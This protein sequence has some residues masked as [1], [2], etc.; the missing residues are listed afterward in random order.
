[1]KYA[2]RTLRRAPGFTAAAV[3]TLAL[4]I[5]ANTTMFGIIN[6][7]LLQRLPFPEPE[8]LVMLWQASIQDRS[9][10]NIVSMPN[11]QD[12]LERSRS[13]ASI[14]LQDSAGRGYSVTGQGEGERVPGLRVTASFFEVLG[15]PPMLG[16]TFLKEEELAGR[17]R[18]VVLSHG[19]WTRRYAADAAIVGKTILVDGKSFLVIG[20]MPPSFV[21]E[22]GGRRELWVPVGWTEGDRDRTSNSF[23]ALARLKPGVSLE[24]AR[25]EMDTIGRALSAEY[26]IQNPKQTVSVDAMSDYGQTRKRSQLAPMLAVV[27]FVLLIACANVANLMLARAASRSR[28]LAVRAALGAGRGRIVRQLLTESV[29]LACAGGVGGLMLAYWGA[30]AIL[31]VLP[32]S[33]S[34]S[35][36]RPVD[37]VAIDCAGPGLYVGRR[38]R[39]RHPVRPGPGVGRVPEQPGQSTAPEHARL[40]RRRQEPA[41]LRVGRPRSGADADRAR[42][43]WGHAGERPRGCSASMPGSIRGTCW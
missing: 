13:F 14:G 27:G 38:H 25:S 28:E 35:D 16:R 39:Q 20:V 19:L 31:P 32:A 11:Y 10:G 33:I 41:A 24:Q 23:V 1:M 4:G 12:W 21:H 29:V 36:F 43:C 26:P 18:V 9:N 34:A 3:L 17:D 37:T 22:Y 7:T 2:L 5:G 40:D 15:I 8:R 30:R 6:A 42:R